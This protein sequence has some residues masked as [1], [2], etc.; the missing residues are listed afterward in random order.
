MRGLS[1]A[2]GS[3]KTE[4]HLPAQ[5]LRSAAADFYSSNANLTAGWLDEAENHARQG[6]FAR[7]GFADQAGSVSPR[8]MLRLTSRT[9]K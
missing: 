2:E 5:G 4:L 3:W 1:A 9:T 8:S 6:A 7:A